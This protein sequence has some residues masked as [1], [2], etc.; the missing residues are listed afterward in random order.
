MSERI[1]SAISGTTSYYDTKLNEAL[2]AASAGDPGSILRAQ[3]AFSQA[4]FALTATS[5]IIK[6]EAEARKGIAKNMSV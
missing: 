5:E 1:D 3:V 6:G 4:Q 2:S